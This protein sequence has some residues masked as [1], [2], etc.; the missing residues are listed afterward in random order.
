MRILCRDWL[1]TRE[2]EE[3]VS[4]M[5]S[6]INL[7]R[8]ARDRA[9]LPIKSPLAEVVV[10][11]TEQKVLDDVSRLEKYILEELNVRKLTVSTDK[12]TYNVRLSAE[13]DHKLLGQRFKKEFKSIVGGIKVSQ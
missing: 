10:V 6:V 2:T 3:A 5:Q 8:L 13:P 1:V 12:T 9:N 4:W 11:H 7:G